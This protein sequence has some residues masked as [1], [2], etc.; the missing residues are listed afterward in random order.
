M[1]SILISH[2]VGP[3]WASY[4]TAIPGQFKLIPSPSRLKALEQDFG[5]M[6]QMF[7]GD[8]MSWASVVATLR[9]LESDINRLSGSGED[10]D[11]MVGRKFEVGRKKDEKW[12]ASFHGFSAQEWYTFNC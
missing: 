10:V 4:D 12:Q 7:Y 9:S 2:S 8:A 1:Q 11:H 5:D 6:Q 3:G